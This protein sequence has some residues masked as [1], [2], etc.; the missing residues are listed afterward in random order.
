MDGA[1]RFELGEQEEFQIKV[2]DSPMQMV[3]NPN[4]NLTDLWS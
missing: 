3:I 4:D 2:S 1:T